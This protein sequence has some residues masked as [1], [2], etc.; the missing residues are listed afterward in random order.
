MIALTP[1]PA[2]ADPMLPAR[3]RLDTV[4]PEFSDV[5][6]LE[7]SPLDGPEP[8]D[9]QPG[10]F[11]MLYSYGVGEVP[12]SISG[13]PDRPAPLSHTIRAVG[14]VTRALQRL[15]P[16]TM[17]GVRGP[18]GHPWPVTEAEGADLVILAG[19]IGIAPLRPLIYWVLNRRRRYGSICIFYGARSPDE[20]LY[21]TELGAWRAR[22][23]LCVEV[24]VDR[25][26]RDWMGKVGV[27]TKLLAN[28]TFSAPDT[29]AC[30]CGPEVMMRYAVMALNE[31][32]V[33]DSRIYLSMERNMKC[34]LGFCGHCQY[35]ADFVCRDGP[36]F[37]FDRIA[38]RFNIR[39]L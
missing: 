23:D 19:G 36:V 5:F 8:F 38:P 14:A 39:E 15:E 12:I 3:F 34:A 2:L 13:D 30:L 28:K 22:F 16:G 11:N 35:G 32:G 24:T 9:F 18:F 6:T 10:Q 20:I 26:S 29:V 37:R 33:D 27:V 7:L 4:R 17:L 21:L 31:Q 1:S 25:A